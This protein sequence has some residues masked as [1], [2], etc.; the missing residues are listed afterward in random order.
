MVIEKELFRTQSGIYMKYGGLY[1]YVYIIYLIYI[2]YTHNI[3]I[4]YA[5]TCT[6]L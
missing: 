3:F 6:S 1:V 5:Y 4:L 2:T